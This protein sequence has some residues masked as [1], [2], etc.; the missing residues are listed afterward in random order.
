MRSS[1]QN[2]HPM[3]LQT[4][5]ASTAH[6]TQ[7][8]GRAAGKHAK[9][10]A[11]C[12]AML[13]LSATHQG[14]K[15]ELEKRNPAAKS[16][17]E[18]CRSIDQQPSHKQNHSSKRGAIKMVGVSQVLRRLASLPKVSVPA[19]GNHG[20]EHRVELHCMVGNATQT[21]QALPQQQGCTMAFRASVPR[22]HVPTA[23]LSTPSRGA[24]C[25]RMMPAGLTLRPLS[26][27]RQPR[28][29]FSSATVQHPTAFNT[30][31]DLAQR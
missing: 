17:L 27:P 4:T 12:F 28:Q 13:G 26:L 6:W 2:S 24:G 31:G 10:L 16:V 5:Y 21:S 22:Q 20:P 3:Q 30:E 1:P 29:Q 7:A 23:S 25:W 18:S 9:A 8:Y 15:P 14:C 11:L 19:T